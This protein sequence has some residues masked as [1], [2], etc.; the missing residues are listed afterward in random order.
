MVPTTKRC[1]RHLRR[2][3][4]ILPRLE[5]LEPRCLLSGPGTLSPNTL[6]HET[7]DAALDLKSLGLG[8]RA[9]VAG[10]IGAG[11]QGAADVNWY[12]FS[13]PATAEVRLSVQAGLAGQPF[14]AAINLYNDAPL[15]VDP[16]T[17]LPTDPYTPDQHRL[18]A[19]DDGGVS[20]GPGRYASIDRL[21]GPGTYWVAVSGSGNDYFSPFLAGS[22]LN[23]RA[24][25]Y[26]L[27]ISATD[28]G[29]SYDD[30]TTP[31][32]I[33]SDPAPGQVLGQSPFVL[34]FELNTA[35][36]D[37]T[38]AG[39]YNDPTTLAQ[40]LFNTTNDFSPGGSAT[41]VTAQYLAAP[42]GALVYFEPQ[43]NELQIDLAAPL[44]S[45]YYEVT[46][47][48]YGPGGGDYVAQF[49]VAGPAGNTDPSQQSG[50][51]TGTAY[52]V[53]GA[54][55]GRLHQLAGAVG[56]DPTDPNGFYQAGVEL[57]HFSIN[58]PGTYAL[59]AEVFAGR[60]GS[61]LNASLTIFK[62]ENH[63]PTFVASDG[64]TANNLP[65]TNNQAV[66]YFDPA[67]F[68]T[69]GPG[70]YY[71]AVSATVNYP[72]P[73]DP[74]NTTFFD[75]TV[76]QSGSVGSTTNTTGPYVL[77]L[78]IQPAAVAAPHVVSVR[79]DMGPAGDGPLTAVRV[80]FDQPVNLLAL[81][82]ERYLA[83]PAAPDGSLASAT[84]GDG[85]QLYD[86]RLGSYDDATNTA[87]FILLEA[88]PPGRYTLTLSGDGPEGI[89]GESGLALAGN[90]PGGAPFTTI[91]TV[92]G[93]AGGQ[94]S[95]ATAS[96]F[97]TPQHAQPVGALFPAQLSGAGVTF[98][99]DSSS[100]GADTEADYDIDLLQSRVYTL[101]VSQLGGEGLP[102]G[103][104]F[105]F[106]DANGVVE[107]S[108]VYDP[109]SG[110]PSI[111]LSAG[112]YVLQVTWSGQVASY[113]LVLGFGT[114]PDNPTPLVVGAG[115]A[116]RVRLLTN[117]T[118]AAPAAAT[119][120][121]GGTAA[122]TPAA[123]N[124]PLPGVFG[125]PGSALLAQGF[126]PLDG[127]LAAGGADYA[128]GDRLLVRAPADAAPANP[129]LSLVIV[130]QAPLAASG[131]GEQTPGP[132]PA[133][134][135][136]STGQGAAT[137]ES[138]SRML[139]VLF[140]FWGWFAIPAPSGTTVPLTPSQDG[141][142]DDG[143][144]VVVPS[145]SAREALA[146]PDADLA[147]A[148]AWALA[149]GVMAGPTIRAQSS[150]RA[151]RTIPRLR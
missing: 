20:T 44:T 8:A 142:G 56:V 136:G 140:E 37:G 11:P 62:V 144:G 7:L 52:D 116:L 13:L 29:T 48:G 105:N 87:T 129:L 59:G 14:D 132:G 122:V 43:A 6:F 5:G 40:L 53:S 41:D 115:P 141:D 94:T 134:P 125:L 107:A 109:A 45:G 98:S 10:A 77:N 30:P 78:L 67:L 1:P 26:Q 149:A 93:S 130:T 22:G 60:I 88:V 145:P 135:G 65:G 28:P 38:V 42:L 151:G 36:D 18:L 114:A 33:A 49:Q 27:S 127:V 131:E 99:R 138:L 80:Q 110:S 143:L 24:G 76:P 12:E 55:D 150:R 91:F 100:A 31:V 86:L 97:D 121:A 147:W 113:D 4:R 124:G 123:A 73:D 46:L 112:K 51:W 66:L 61:P 35:L 9:S 25:N 90:G 103:L 126:S 120:S 50:T 15:V 32:V 84:L 17:S 128:G 63:V 139:D 148:W 92:T 69:V 2:T 19:H 21:L 102:P 34:R 70:D 85:H 104:T 72:D 118:G 54:A 82:F 57:Y 146:G 74:S 133:A 75:P 71:L 101:N 16:F 3:R 106:I 81:A 68:A 137:S 83:T 95:W 117:P 108:Y 39:Y 64:N 58:Q 89:V 23:G 96:G 119:S 111:Y 47:P 79:P